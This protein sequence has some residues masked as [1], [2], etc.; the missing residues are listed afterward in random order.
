M[1]WVSPKNA[2]KVI[3]TDQASYL[4][5]ET[6]LHYYERLMLMCTSM[7][8]WEG[9]PPSI[10]ERFIEKSLF[11]YGIISF[12]EDDKVGL[13]VAKCTQFDQ[14]NIYDEPIGWNC[15][16]NNGYWKNYKN[17]EIEIIRNNKYSIPTSQLIQHH[18]NR[19]FNIERT[20]DSNLYQQ[21]KL[22]IIKTSES[23][24]LATENLMKKYDEHGYTV[25]ANDKL[26]MAEIEVLNFNIPYIG[27]ELE[28]HKERKWNDLLNM[29][30]I[31][32]VNTQ[33]KE[34]LI[35][36]E[37]NANNQMINLDVDVFLAERK[38]AVERINTRYS[39]NIKVSLRNG[40]EE[41]EEKEEDNINE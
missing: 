35:T 31:N 10:P 15:F 37:A 29:L 41:V 21:R 34:R 40:I 28:D 20:I 3:E 7:F 16:S 12:L 27:L 36:D 19:I 17:D 23:Q 32:T 26:K 5:S 4:T 22:A 30:G 18:L 33:K 8:V 11:D 38:E 2:M 14:L 24:R 1:E 39:L 6:Y 13:M 9:L 25:I